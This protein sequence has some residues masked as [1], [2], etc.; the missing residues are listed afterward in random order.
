M[1]LDATGL[2]QFVMSCRVLGLEVEAA[3]VAVAVE[4]LAQDGAEAAFAAMVET[5]RNLP[6]R[7]LYR[8]CGFTQVAGGWLHPVAPRPPVP[9]HITLGA[10]ELAEAEPATEELVAA[11]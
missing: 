5:E 7:D 9:A 4:S 1:V 8:R 11:P 3:A 10:A 2:A 6:C